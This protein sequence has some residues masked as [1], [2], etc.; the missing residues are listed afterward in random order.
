MPVGK[1]HARLAVVRVPR[2]PFTTGLENRVELGRDSTGDCT[3]VSSYRAPF[4]SW[5][6]SAEKA[7]GF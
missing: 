4:T 7:S 3:P 2:N 1:I 6:H 5:V